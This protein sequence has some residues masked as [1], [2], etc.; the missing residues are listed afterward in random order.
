VLLCVLAAGAT[1]ATVLGGPFMLVSLYSGI[2]Y[3]SIAAILLHHRRTYDVLSTLGRPRVLAVVTI[4]VLI[5]QFGTELIGRGKPLYGL[6]GMLITLLI[7]GIVS[8]RTRAIDWLSSRPL[9][10]IGALSY[11]L[12]LIHN[13]GLNAAEMV[14]PLE[15]GLPGSLLSTT[16]G[17]GASVIVAAAIHKWYEEPLRLVGA[18]ISKARRAI[19]TVPAVREVDVSP[20]P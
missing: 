6:Y 3:G 10:Y 12:Y 7:I 9:V 18:R 4:A 20:A 8:T 13:F 2:C 11:V 1:A 15:W 17:I 16:I 14:I 5:M 19:R